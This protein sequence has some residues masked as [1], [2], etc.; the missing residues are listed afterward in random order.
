MV[1]SRW[2]SGQ[3]GERSVVEPWRTIACLRNVQ[4]G[5]ASARYGRSVD[6]VVG[7]VDMM[8]RS[9]GLPWFG[10]ASEPDLRV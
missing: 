10:L 3:L 4:T 8:A 6:V 7:V 9:T 2:F 1:S 5:G